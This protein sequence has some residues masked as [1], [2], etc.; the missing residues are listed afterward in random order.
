MRSAITSSSE[1]HRRR[2]ARSLTFNLLRAAEMAEMAVIARMMNIAAR[3]FGAMAGQNRIRR[4]V[5]VLLSCQVLLARD[6]SAED[7]DAYLVAFV[8]D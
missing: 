4:K 8:D 3:I 7:D 5:M 1:T 6:I 2:T